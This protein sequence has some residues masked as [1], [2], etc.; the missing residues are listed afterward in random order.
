MSI[1]RSILI[2]VAQL[3]V[4]ERVADNRWWPNIS[5][6]LYRVRALLSEIHTQAPPQI[7]DELARAVLA[8]YVSHN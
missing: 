7:V 8:S 6:L 5:G 1:R 4:Y 2:C 3:Q